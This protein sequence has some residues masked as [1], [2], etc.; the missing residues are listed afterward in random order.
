MAKAKKKKFPIIPIT[1][2]VLVGVFLGYKLLGNKAIQLKKT[3][4][5]PE[6][7]QIY[8]NEEYGFSLAHPPGTEVT[9]H[10]LG[11]PMSIDGFLIYKEYAFDLSVWVYKKDC[12][13]A[14]FQDE[15]VNWWPKTRLEGQELSI[16]GNRAFEIYF[17]EYG[18]V[19]KEVYITNGQGLVIFFIFENLASINEAL[20]EDQQALV[21]SIQFSD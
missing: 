6:G 19:R 20:P 17:D 7:W 4:K 8:K 14:C 21:N 3:A 5:I 15:L 1:L 11:N 16:N 9:R 2:L 10:M 13:E 12:D 18:A